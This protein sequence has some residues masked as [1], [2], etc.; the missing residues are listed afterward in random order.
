MTCQVTSTAQRKPQREREHVLSIYDSTTTS[1]NVMPCKVL[2]TTFLIILHS[3][4]QC[5]HTNEA[6]C[7]GFRCSLRNRHTLHSLVIHG[8]SKLDT[9]TNA[10]LVSSSNSVVHEATKRKHC[11]EA[12]NLREAFNQCCSRCKKLIISSIVLCKHRLKGCVECITDDVVI[13]SFQVT[14]FEDVFEGAFLCKT[15]M[16]IKLSHEHLRLCECVLNLHTRKAG[17]AISSSFYTLIPL[18]VSI[19]AIPLST[20]LNTTREAFKQ[21]LLNVFVFT[22]ERHVSIMCSVRVKQVTHLLNLD[23]LIHVSYTQSF[24]TLSSHRTT[25]THSIHGVACHAEQVC[26]R[27]T[28]VELTETHDVDGRSSRRRHKHTTPRVLDVACILRRL[29]VLSQLI[30]KLNSFDLAFNNLVSMQESSINSL[31]NLR[32]NVQDLTTFANLYSKKITEALCSLSSLTES[33]AHRL[34]LCVDSTKLFLR[35]ILHDAS[36]NVRDSRAFRERLTCILEHLSET[37]TTI[38]T[39]H[40]FLDELNRGRHSIKLIHTTFNFLTPR[41]RYVLDVV[42][43]FLSLL[44]IHG[45]ACTCTLLS[46][47]SSSSSEFFTALCPHSTNTKL[48][49][50]ITKT[51][52][53]SKLAEAILC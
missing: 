12:R 49:L 50:C 42:S 41:V 27:L 21:N 23:G 32:H 36:H 15:K 14:C 6:T 43:S 17:S 30:C 35:H 1:I 31:T 51:R 44:L 26:H 16:L 39:D 29:K 28:D 48:R 40:D 24:T 25:N 4:T 8:T 13:N 46:K 9:A 7:K 20:T 45:E 53:T 19:N 37:T 18:S 52:S 2:I 47:L 34:K 3:K 10:P 5:R 11:A 33:D 38:S 22:Q